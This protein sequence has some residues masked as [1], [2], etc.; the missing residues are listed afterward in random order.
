MKKAT[1]VKKFNKTESV[2]FE[3]KNGSNFSIVYGDT[4]YTQG[5]V[6]QDT[7]LF[8]G[9]NISKQSLAL[10]TRQSLLININIPF[11][12]NLIELFFN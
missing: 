2:T 12:I 8:A 1:R 3:E 4:S 7:L 11:S 9:L 6:G 10:I 5:Y